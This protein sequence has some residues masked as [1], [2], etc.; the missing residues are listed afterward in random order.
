MQIPPFP[1]LVLS[2]NMIILHFSNY[3]TFNIYLQLFKWYTVSV[4]LCFWTVLGLSNYRKNKYILAIQWQKLKNFCRIDICYKYMHNMA[5]KGLSIFFPD[6]LQWQMEM[7]I[8]FQAYNTVFTPQINLQNLNIW[9][10]N[11]K[12]CFGTLER[13]SRK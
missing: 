9:L 1:T 5:Y 11:Y 7:G 2:L 13:I 6:F 4:W 3:A 8:M 10:S 12:K